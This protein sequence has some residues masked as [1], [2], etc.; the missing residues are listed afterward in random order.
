MLALLKGF[1]AAFAL[2]LPGA[3]LAEDP[4]TVTATGVQGEVVDG[5]YRLDASLHV[6]LSDIQQE[7]LENGVPLFFDLHV[8][9]LH[10]RDWI[11]DARIG[12]ARQRYR[13]TYHA[14]SRQY[15]LESLSESRAWTFPTLNSVLE[16]LGRV[17]DL[18]LVEAA[19]LEPGEEYMGRL[20]LMLD[21]GALPLP[22]R[23]DAYTREGWRLLSEWYLWSL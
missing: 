10:Q 8:E 18:E 19:E 3:A 1:I 17:Q 2:W 5:I 21:R 14:L 12:H 15:R 23:V 11:W 6:R 20:R 16:A 9:V 22:M 13:L 7:A 4:G